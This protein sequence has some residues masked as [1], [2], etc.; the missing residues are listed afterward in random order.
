[1]QEKTNSQIVRNV[2]GQITLIGIVWRFLFALVVVMGTYNPSG[3][4]YFDWG[5]RQMPPFEPVRVVVGISLLIGWV[6]FVRASM[7]SLGGL[8]LILISAFCAALLWLVIDW[9]LINKDSVTAVTYSVLMIISII[10]T[11]GLTWSHIRR[12]LTGQVDVDEA[13]DVD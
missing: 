1:M 12:R 11:V 6:I 10:L 7:R 2:S 8:G 5:I 4:S 3:H 9:G 13:E